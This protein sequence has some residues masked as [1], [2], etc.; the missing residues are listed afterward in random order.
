MALNELIPK[1]TKSNIVANIDR[2]LQPATDFI[3]GNPLVSTAAIGLGTTGLV[4]GAA[5]LARRKKTS[6]K[7]K[8]SKTKKKR[9]TRGRSR[10]IKFIS[11]QKHEIK[12][13]RKRKA[14]VYKRKGKYYKYPTR[15]TKKR[16][17]GVYYTKN[18]QPYK[19]MASGKARFIKGK[20]RKK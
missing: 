16:T 4:A 19:I 11:R 13:R 6:T 20:R 5:T 7:K 15:K 3:R 9:T 12:R 18:G 2:I 17:G 1:S 14:K 10:D 8:K